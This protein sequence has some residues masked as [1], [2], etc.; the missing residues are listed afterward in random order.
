MDAEILNYL[1]DYQVIKDKAGF[2]DNAID[3]VISRLDKENISYQV[4]YTDKNPII[5]NY[6]NNNYFKIYEKIKEKNIER[7]ELVLF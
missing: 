5:K 6:E 1:F 3:K 4:V 7:K 2:P